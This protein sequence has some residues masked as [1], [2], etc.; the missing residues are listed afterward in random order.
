[1]NL[2][3]T[4]FKRKK[5][6]KGKSVDFSVDTIILPN[7]KTAK[8]EYLEHPGAVTVLP[9]LP[10]KKIILVKQYRYPIKK[11]TYELPAGKLD[12]YKNESLKN[13]VLRELEEETGYKSKKVKKLFSFWPTPAFATEVIHIFVATKLYKGKK[14]T[15]EDEF[16]K[17]KIIPFSQA[18]EW[19]KKGKIKDSKSVIGILYWKHF[20][21]KK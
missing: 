5:I 8:R 2:K 3:E 17:T 21:E 13:C 6:Y 1:M 11:I 16:L 12:K 15:D 19:I 9:I 18:I 10:D 7:G 14:N 4:L 20:C